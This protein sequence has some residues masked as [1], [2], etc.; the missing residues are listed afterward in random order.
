[1]FTSD[2]RIVPAVMGKTSTFLQLAMVIAILIAPEVSGYLGWW[3]YF[4][5]ILWILTASAAILS[6]LIYIRVGKGYI[7]QFDNSTANGN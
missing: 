2:V 3:I 7:E 5:R 4:V 6:T 1:M